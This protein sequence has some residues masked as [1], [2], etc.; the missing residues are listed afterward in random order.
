MMAVAMGTWMASVLVLFATGMAVLLI[1][2]G[3]TR[4]VP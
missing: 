4:H 2:S 1:E 3:P